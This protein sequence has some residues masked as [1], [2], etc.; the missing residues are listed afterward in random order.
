MAIEVLPL[1]VVNMLQ[2]IAKSTNASVEMTSNNFNNIQLEEKF[3]EGARIYL[4]NPSILVLKIAMMI[5]CL[6]KD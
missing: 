2:Q 5:L 6:K 3:S 1:N 4:Y